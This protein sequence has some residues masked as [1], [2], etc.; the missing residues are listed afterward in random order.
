LVYNTWRGINTVK[1]NTSPT[2]QGTT[3]RLAAQ[4][5]LSLV[6]KLWQGLTAPQRTGW[7]QYAIDHPVTD[8]TG[9]PKRLTGSNWFCK[10]NTLLN[11]IGQAVVNSAP[12]VAAPNAPTGLVFTYATQ[13]VYANYA[14]IGYS[15]QSLMVSFTAPQSAGITGKRE[16]A[17]YATFS[18][19]NAVRPTLV[20]PNPAAGTLTGFC[21]VVDHATGLESTE[22]S[23]TVVSTGV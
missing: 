7:S 5:R 17:S 11:I 8:W 20:L 18:L 22:V 15:T 1:T 21:K 23:A 9:S 16:S 13:A 19:A 4:A 2:G 10:C 14:T 6:S 3:K 12:G